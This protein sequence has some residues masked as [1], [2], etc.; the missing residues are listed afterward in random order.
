MTVSNALSSMAINGND[1]KAGSTLTIRGG[2]SSPIV[3]KAI[4]SMVGIKNFSSVTNALDPISTVQVSLDPVALFG[5]AIG[6]PLTLAHYHVWS[7]YAF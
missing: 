6:G 2:A 5:G 3:T 4:A 7:S 1:V